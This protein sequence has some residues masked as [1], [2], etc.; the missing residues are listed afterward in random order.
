M[1][2]IL[3]LLLDLVMVSITH[4]P[5]KIGEVLFLK[6]MGV[7]PDGPMVVIIATGSE[8]RGFKPS[9][10]RWNFQGV[11]NPSMTSSGR[12]VEP[13]VPCRRFTVLEEPQA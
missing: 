2:S 6:Q 7:D 3:L 4:I 8:V 1:K 9:R 10:R 5:S 12:E 11:K 13:W